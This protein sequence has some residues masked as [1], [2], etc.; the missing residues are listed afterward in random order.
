MSGKVDYEKL[1][2]WVAKFH[3]LMSTAWPKPDE[4]ALAGASVFIG[5]TLW[6]ALENAFPLFQETVEAANNYDSTRE[7]ICF[8]TAFKRLFFAVGNQDRNNKSEQ[9]DFALNLLYLASGV[10]YYR[11]QELSS[12]QPDIGKDFIRIKPFSELLNLCRWPDK[13]GSV[14]SVFDSIVVQ[15]TMCAKDLEASNDNKN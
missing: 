9:V 5:T 12:T 14:K 15:M 3:S 8:L 13:T 11:L 4:P 10:F 2:M 7:I 1:M 6:K